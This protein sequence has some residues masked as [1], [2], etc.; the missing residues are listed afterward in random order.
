M[1]RISTVDRPVYRAPTKGRCFLT[2]KGAALAEAGAMIAAKYPTEAAEFE[3]YGR[4]TYAG[5]HWTTDERLV[6]VR[7]RLA[8]RLLRSFTASRQKDQPHD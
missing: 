3:D 1:G 8:E 4:M 7:K 5:F 6:R 2:A